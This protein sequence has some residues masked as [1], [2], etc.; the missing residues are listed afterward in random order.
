[1]NPASVPVI[2]QQPDQAEYPATE[3]QTLPTFTYESYLTAAEPPRR[4]MRRVPSNIGSMRRPRPG[5]ARCINTP[6]CSPMRTGIRGS[7]PKSFRRCGRLR[8]TYHRRRA[9]TPT[10]SS[11]CPYVHCSRTS[12][13]FST[14]MATVRE[15]PHLSFCARICKERY[16]RNTHRATRPSLRVWGRIWRSW[17]RDRKEAACVR[18]WPLDLRG[19]C[20]QYSVATRLAG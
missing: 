1:M 5:S 8:R 14:P 2:P 17:R 20:V 4:G 19:C 6:R 16:P 13:C 15:L 9:R 18:G 3:L 12:N 10:Q 11:R 7:G